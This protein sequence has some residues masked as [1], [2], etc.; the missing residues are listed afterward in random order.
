MEF[1]PNLCNLMSRDSFSE[2]LFEVLWYDEAQN[3]DKISLTH[4][5][6]NFPYD[7]V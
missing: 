5:S 4:F 7:V 2:D 3:I 1:V 6:K